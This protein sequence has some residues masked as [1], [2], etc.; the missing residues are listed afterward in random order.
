MPLA[1]KTLNEGGAFRS[2]FCHRSKVLVIADFDS[3]T[4]FFWSVSTF[5]QLS[6]DSNVTGI[7][8]YHHKFAGR[9]CGGRSRDYYFTSKPVADPAG[10][11]ALPLIF[12]PTWKI[13]FETTCPHLAEGLDPPLQSH[14]K[15]PVF[16]SIGLHTTG[17]GVRGS[18]I[19]LNEGFDLLIWWWIFLYI[20]V[21]S[22]RLILI[23]GYSKSC[24]PQF[25]LNFWSVFIKHNFTTKC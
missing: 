20:H 14:H 18:V 25:E 19:I 8:V 11:P 4:F 24:A 1:L 22:K 2:L 9:G 13:V 12:R 3:V 15:L 6:I 10:P 5:W 16:F 17:K 7:Q 23:R 21:W